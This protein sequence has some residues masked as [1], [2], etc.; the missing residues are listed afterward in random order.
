MRSKTK[1]IIPLERTGDSNLNI[2]IKESAKIKNK[3]LLE[4]EGYLSKNDYLIELL[5]Y[6]L[7]V[8][9]ILSIL[10]IS[11]FSKEVFAKGVVY[12]RVFSIYIFSVILFFFLNKLIEMKPVDMFRKT[13]MFFL[14]L[15]GFSFV[16]FI[17]SYLMKKDYSGLKGF[18]FA[19][20]VV[21]IFM[22]LAQ[23]INL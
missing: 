13:M 18:G 14:V 9:F 21:F 8:T 7:M 2:T 11:F 15:I 3:K 12:N 16:A 4:A 22:L 10:Y 6:T 19:I 1:S 17:V 23:F 20:G 5:K